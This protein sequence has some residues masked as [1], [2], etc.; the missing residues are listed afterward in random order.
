VSAIFNQ[1]IYPLLT[2]SIENAW[3]SAAVITVN[4]SRMVDLTNSMSNEGYNVAP[5]CGIV[6][7]FKKNAFYGSGIQS[8]IFK[9][10]DTVNTRHKFMLTKYDGSGNPLATPLAITNLVQMQGTI[11]SPTDEETQQAFIDL[12]KLGSS[13]LSD[14]GGL[15]ANIPGDPGVVGSSQPPI[16]FWIPYSSGLYSQT[17]IVSVSIQIVSPGST[18]PN[19]TFSN[20]LTVVN[21]VNLYE[22]VLLSHTEPT[23]VGSTGILTV[24]IDN[25]TL[26]AHALHSDFY[27]TSVTFTSSL[28]PSNNVV[29]RSTENNG[30]FDIIIRNPEP[31]GVDNPCT[32]SVY[33]TITDPNGGGTIRGPV[34]DEYEIEISNEPTSNNFETSTPDTGFEYTTFHSDGVSGFTLR[35]KFKPD[36]NTDI[37][38]VNVYFES[39]SDFLNDNGTPYTSMFHLFDL[40]R[41]RTQTIHTQQ[42][43]LQSTQPLTSDVTDGVIILG[44]GGLSTAT[45]RNYGAGKIVIEPYITKK[46]ITSTDTQIKISGESVRKSIYNIPVISK[47]ENIV[48]NGGV[49]ELFNGTNMSFDNALSKYSGL[50]TVTA[51]YVLTVNYQN[52]SNSIVSN[53]QFTDKYA[54]S[55]GSSPSN[56]S[57]NLLVRVTAGDETEYDSESATLVFDSVSLDVS[58]MNVVVQRNSN[59]TSLSVMRGNYTVSPSGASYLNVTEVKLVDNGTTTNTNPTDSGV[60]VL[61]CTNSVESDVHPDG[62]TNTYSIVRENVYD[63]SYMLYLQYRVKAGVDYLLQYSSQNSATSY[64]SMPD[65]VSLKPYPSMNITRYVIATRPEVTVLYSYVESS[66]LKLKVRIDAKGLKDE[67]VQSVVFLLG[68]D[69]DYTDAADTSAGEGAQIILSFTSANVSETYDYTSGISANI[70]TGEEATLTTVDVDGLNE[71]SGLSATWKLKAGSL[72]NNDESVLTFPDLSSGAYGGFVSSKPISVVA[73]ASTRLG[74]DLDIKTAAL[75]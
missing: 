57:L 7:S 30:V 55:L 42:W 67:G 60:Y 25:P 61:P 15:Y 43:T 75:S 24:P 50:S 45:W 70:N 18:L 19:A 3:V 39:E 31:N 38:G 44:S 47:V 49:L 4:G 46:V 73:V 74:I 56:Y 6:G 14:S 62:S 27:M 11:A 41:D 69:G 33:Y 51:S 63:L 64:E 68:Q 59:N 58:T 72:D 9:D 22:M 10:L 17:D 32:Y 26:P 37:D 5:E 28:D 34:S 16:Y 52:Q 35:I 21:N 53:D 36:G 8:G 66:K 65:Y 54:I 71:G 2:F 48:L 29:T 13:V 12:V 1:D 20:N 40:P 23:Y